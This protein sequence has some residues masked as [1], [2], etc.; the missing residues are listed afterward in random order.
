MKQGNQSFLKHLEDMTLITSSQSVLIVE[1]A[2]SREDADGSKLPM[3]IQRNKDRDIDCLN[4]SRDR[5]NKYDNDIALA[6]K[7]RNKIQGLGSSYAGCLG[8]DAPETLRNSIIIHDTTKLLE[9]IFIENGGNIY[10]ISESCFVTLIHSCRKRKWVNQVNYVLD[11]VNSLVTKGVPE[12]N[13]L[14]LS[15]IGPTYVLYEAALD[16]FFAMDCIDLAWNLYQKIDLN[17]VFDNDSSDKSKEYPFFHFII[18]GFF[19]CGN[20]IYALK[21]FENMISRKIEPTQKLLQCMMRGLG[22][23]FDE[24]INILNTYHNPTLLCI[25]LESSA[26]LEN[27]SRSANFIEECISNTNT[28]SLSNSCKDM[29]TKLLMTM[30]AEFI[31]VCLMI[32]VSSFSIES[33]YNNIK[34]FSIYLLILI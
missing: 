8:P 12:K 5:D 27:S 3:S 19:Q 28:G 26:V 1:S 30:D 25:L 21:V 23:S 6:L 32:A 22:S 9:K 16:A 18:K 29:I 11:Y 2:N 10:R 14:P 17:L 31:T 13:V 15:H 7:Q 33:A 20:S 24:G 34:R 4:T